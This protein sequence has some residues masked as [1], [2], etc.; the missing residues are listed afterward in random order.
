MTCFGY[1]NWKLFMFLTLSSTLI[2]SF[3]HNKLLIYEDPW[4]LLTWI[5]GHKITEEF[6]CV[7]VFRK[8]RP[9]LIRIYRISSV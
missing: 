4:L 6:P 5:K 8:M 3:L 1:P 7:G 9:T 2:D